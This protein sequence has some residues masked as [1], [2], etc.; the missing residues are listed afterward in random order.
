LKGRSEI[1]ETDKREE[2]IE[3]NFDAK[4]IIPVDKIC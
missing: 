3:N 2:E 1:Y 4:E